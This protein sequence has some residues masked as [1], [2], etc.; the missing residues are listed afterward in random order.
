[1]TTSVGAAVYLSATTRVKIEGFAGL[2][3][4]RG[5]SVRSEKFSCK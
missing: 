3:S 4:E 1:M 5:S 2:P